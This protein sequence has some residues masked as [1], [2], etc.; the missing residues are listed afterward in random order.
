MPSPDGPAGGEAMQHTTATINGTN[1]AV[2]LLPWMAEAPR[3]WIPGYSRVLIPFSPSEVKN[4]R[5]KTCAHVQIMRN[6]KLAFGG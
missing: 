3:P 6:D 4:S 2:F 1:R 5:G